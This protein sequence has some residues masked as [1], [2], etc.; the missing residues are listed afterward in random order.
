MGAY[1]GLGLTLEP[2]GLD[3]VQL[4]ALLEAEDAERYL[5][6]VGRPLGHREGVVLLVE[7]L[8]DHRQLVAVE[9]PVEL[10]HKSPSHVHWRWRVLPDVRLTWRTGSSHRKA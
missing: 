1:S 10:Q 5:L 9:L 4:A 8:P 3:L 6:P 7:G 2:L